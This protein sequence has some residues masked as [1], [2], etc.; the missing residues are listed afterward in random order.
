ML[1]RDGEL[2]DHYMCMLFNDEVRT[3]E[4]VRRLRM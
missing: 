1:T 3:Y 4:Q 2:T